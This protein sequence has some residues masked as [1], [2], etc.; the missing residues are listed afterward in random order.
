MKKATKITTNTDTETVAESKT[1]TTSRL[2]AS[3]LTPFQQKLSNANVVNYQNK[4]EVKVLDPFF[5]FKKVELAL[6]YS[7]DFKVVNKNDQYLT[8][9]VDVDFKGN[10]D[11]VK[12]WW[13][14]N[15]DINSESTYTVD[16]IKKCDPK[17]NTCG[18]PVE[19]PNK[20]SI[21]ID[22]LKLDAKEFGLWT[23][24]SQNSV[25]SRRFSKPAL[26]LILA[27]YVPNSDIDKKPYVYNCKL[28][29]RD[30][31]ACC[32]SRMP[33]ELNDTICFSGFIKDNLSMM[34]LL[35]ISSLFFL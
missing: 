13:M 9:T 7:S 5:D 4:Y 19:I 21:D 35:I 11:L 6:S 30:F 24:C 20:V 14:L 16:Q 10:R 23:T 12:C 34:M 1:D 8:A 2:L 22:Y 15:N 29:H 28:G 3:T 26:A 18:Q 31:P 32:D 27:T 25:I 33:S 17:V